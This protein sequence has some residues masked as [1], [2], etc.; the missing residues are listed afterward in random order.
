M[1]S[2]YYN[3]TGLPYN[4][5]PPIETRF[6]KGHK[7]YWSGK[8]MPTRT[9]EHKRKIAESHMGEKN[10]AYGKIGELNPR[11]IKDRTLLKKTDHRANSA[12]WEWKRKCKIRDENKCRIADDNCKGQLEVH[13]ILSYKDHP[14]LRY[15]IN[16]GITL[17]HFHHPRSR[18]KEK[19]LSPYFIYL[20]TNNK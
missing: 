1:P 19:E 13:H 10:P 3:S 6:I 12:N 18:I 20:I 15:E 17:C 5:K 7:G 4:R 14:E 9:E 11:Y 16:N 8:K 2:G